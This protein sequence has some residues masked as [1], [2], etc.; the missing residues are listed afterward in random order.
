MLAAAVVQLRCPAF[1]S[2]SKPL[3]NELY[4]VECQSRSRCSSAARAQLEFRCSQGGC[5]QRPVKQSARFSWA[6]PSRF[7]S[8]SSRTAHLARCGDDG[9]GAGVPEGSSYDD[10]TGSSRGDAPG[11]HANAP[12]QHVND[13]AMQPRHPDDEAASDGSADAAAFLR[14]AKAMRG[15]NSDDTLLQELQSHTRRL[16]ALE[17][18]REHMLRADADVDLLECAL[19]IAKHAHPNLDEVQCRQDIEKLSDDV[20]EALPSDPAPLRIVQ[21]INSTL[22][23]KNGFRGADPQHYYNPDNSC[24]NMVLATRVGIPI[25]LGLLWWQ[26]AKRCAL[27]VIGLNLPGH[28]MLAPAGEDFEVFIDPHNNGEILFLEDAAEKLASVHGI[29]AGQVVIDPRVLRNKALHAIRPRT[30][31]ARMLSNLKGIYVNRSDVASTLTIVQYMRATVPQETDLIRDEGICLYA[32]D[33]TA[34][35]AVCLRLYLALEPRAADAVQI[36]RMLERFGKH[37]AHDEDESQ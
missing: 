17:D 32:L 19:L 27:P 10:A 34:E 30:F 15:G 2:T 23:S 33:R 11:Q 6:Q 8:S 37:R 9:G 29:K 16:Q 26:V 21:A 24:M 14:A 5:A 13:P 12:G 36:R 4:S 28:F 7:D 31:L 20:W 1:S 3:R 35:A 22:Y 18:F 25:T